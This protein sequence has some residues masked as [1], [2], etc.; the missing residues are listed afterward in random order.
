MT[1]VMTILTWASELD[2]CSD[3]I[4]WLEA[5]PAKTSLAV[6]WEQCHRADWMLWA[7]GKEDIGYNSYALHEFA[8]YIAEGALREEGIPNPRSVEAIRVKRA[9]LQGE[10]T[11]WELSAA[12]NTAWGAPK[13]ATITVAL[14]AAKDA[15]R[16]V[17][18]DVA[19][20]IF[21]TGTWKTAWETAWTTVGD[22]QAHL[23]RQLLGNPFARRGL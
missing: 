22:A 4:D 23:L 10:A 1:N 16:A 7:L 20:T 9:W 2:N 18:W 3:A 6:A 21:K 17:A 12:R 8:L 11:D 13:A 5:F 15:V 19:K 14:D